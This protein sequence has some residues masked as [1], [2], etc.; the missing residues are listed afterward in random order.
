LKS[1]RP[2]GE[3][4]AAL[5]RRWDTGP[6]A[7]PNIL[8]MFD[9]YGSGYRWLAVG[10]VMLGAITTLLTSTTINVAIPEIMGAFGIGQERAQWLSTGFLAST[11]VT[12]LMSTWSIRA[13]GMRA[14][15]LVGMGGFMAGS[16]LG[17][18]GPNLEVLIASRVIQGVSSG[19][20]GPLGMLI[21][22]QVFPPDRRGRAMGIFGIGAVLAPALGPTLGG[23]LIDSFNWR[24]VF[25][26][27]VPI[28]ILSL[29]LGAL[30]IPPRDGEG[31]WPAFDWVGLFL[32]CAFIPSLLVGLTN[33]QSEGW[34]STTILLYFAVAFGSGIGFVLWEGICPEPMLDLR[35]FTN[36]GFAAASVVT[37]VFG[38]G[39]YGSTYLVPIFLQGIQGLTPTQSGLLLM[40]P[41][42]ML[43]VVFP[44]SG[45]LSD[46]LSS[47]GLIISGLLLFAWSSWL[48][49]DLDLHTPFWT[50]VGWIVIGRIGLGIVMPT[51]SR[52]SLTA[53]P[54][55]LLAH[56]SSAVNFVR[57]LGG[58]FGV[59]LL[60]IEVERRTQLYGDAF[61]AA[62][63]A[64]NPQTVEL[65][66]RVQELLLEAGVA[67]AH[68]L[69]GA[70]LYLGG[71]IY[72]QASVLA[73]RDGFL[74]VAV[75]FLLTLIPAWFMSRMAG[76][77][78]A[79]TAP[80]RETGDALGPAGPALAPR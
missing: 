27:A 16:L 10:T 29:P 79:G 75:T 41:G 58:A 73:F 34:G 32:L 1:G 2:E 56:G 49:A 13:I 78:A 5:A 36:R 43:A 72:Q 23:M 40:P 70:L 20:L 66:Q 45:A 48:M 64:G 24:Y 55:E 59:N 53:L 62:Q 12:M 14:T 37:F 47:R 42:L 60:A 71:T 11:T 68:A 8:A 76:G 22:F 38:A 46:R 35:L 57:Q 44:F 9:R 33:G 4:P 3:A 31:A 39:L 15:Y 17:G 28:G 61:S 51:L 69:P 21:M 80:G 63:T 52:A 65:L 74:I 77:Y 18:V 26:A 25:L 7:T 6:D 50:L 30:F 67:D 54:I 19:L